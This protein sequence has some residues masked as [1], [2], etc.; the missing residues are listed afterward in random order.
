MF[1]TKKKLNEL[2]KEKEAET[3]MHFEREEH[4]RERDRWESDRINNL[5]K[6]VAVLEST[7]RE[8]LSVKK[9]FDEVRMSQPT[10]F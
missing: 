6:R 5:E 9:Q 7:I 10:I 2:L 8:L 1:I 3:I 4:D